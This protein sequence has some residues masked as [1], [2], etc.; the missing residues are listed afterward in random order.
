MVIN[1]IIDKNKLFY[2]EQEYN[3]CTLIKQFSFKH[4]QIYVAKIQGR[5]KQH[6]H[7]N[8][9]YRKQLKSWMKNNKI[10]K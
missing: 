6:T 4:I 2:S 9:S 3:I 8:T 5:T 1:Q 7:T 10:N